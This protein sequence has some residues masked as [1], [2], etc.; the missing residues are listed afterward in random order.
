MVNTASDKWIINFFY[1][2]DDYENL[3]EKDFPSDLVKSYDSLIKDLGRGFFKLVNV[4]SEKPYAAA[5]PNS[6]KDIYLEKYAY[7]NESLRE[8]WLI[9][10]PKLS[11]HTDAAYEQ[12][13]HNIQ[14]ATDMGSSITVIGPIDDSQDLVVQSYESKQMD[15]EGYFENPND[16]DNHQNIDDL[17]LYV[18]KAL[19]RRGNNNFFLYDICPPFDSLHGAEFILNKFMSQE[20]AIYK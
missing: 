3:S 8:I 18:Q 12:I 1:D 7:K 15:D 5:L 4:K 2:V 10:T 6:V 11:Q 19:I 16:E 20:R 13:W 17:P 9:Y 14:D